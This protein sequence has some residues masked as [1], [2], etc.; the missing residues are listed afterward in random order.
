MENVKKEMAQ[1]LKTEEKEVRIHKVIKNNDIELDALMVVGRDTNISPTI[2][3]NPY[4]EEHQNGRDFTEIVFEIFHLYLDHCGKMTFSLE[5][6]QDFAQIKKKVAFRIINTKL[7][8]KL[9][10]DIP[11][12]KFLDLSIV[13]YTMIDQGEEGNGSA[14]ALI[15]NSHLDLW[16]IS[17]EELHRV[18]M[19]NTPRMLGWEIRS[20][21]AII[22]DM[23]V[24]EFES[25][26]GMQAIVR[27][28]GDD[29]YY[30]RVAEEKLEELNEHREDIKMFVLTNKMRMNGAACILYQGVL[31]RFAQECACNIFI[32]PSSIHEVILV[33]ARK[34]ITQSELDCMVRDVNREA[35]EDGEILSNHAYLYRKESNKIVM[36]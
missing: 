32:L 9:L 22:K 27:E 20:M 26:E 36:S 33:P 15:H 11:S 24:K 12:K 14:T 23:L 8:E 35:V 34:G 31:Q 21:D 19:E 7:N 30:D 1:L 18:A 2:Y 10:K 5:E 16:G 3:L 29:T 25:D 13:Y 4:Y 28:S 17:K 6:F